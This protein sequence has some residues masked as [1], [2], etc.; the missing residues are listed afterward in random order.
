MRGEKH[1]KKKLVPVVISILVVLGQVSALADPLSD[2]LQ[3]QQNQLQQDKNALKAV[4]D[5][6]EELESKIEEM[7]MHIED[8]LRIIEDNKRQ[9]AQT[10]TEI[11]GAQGEVKKA[12]DEVQESKELLG[13]RVRAMYKSGNSGYLEMI[14]QS[15]NI[16]DFLSKIEW[17]NR[18]VSFDKKMILTLEEKERELVKKKE[19]L[20][21][22]KEEL[23]ALKN[24]NDQ[25]LAHLKTSMDEQKKLIDEVKSQEKIFAAKVKAT[26]NLV[27]TTMRQIQQ[28]RNSV[29]AYNPSRG[30]A[31]ISDNAIIDYASNFLGTPYVW[32][33]TKPN[34]GFDCSGFT[35]YV[36]AHFGIKLGRTTW[37]QINDGVAVARQDLQPGDLVFYGSKGNPTHMGIYVGNDSYIHA[38][39]TGDVIKIS[40]YIRKDY[41]TARRVK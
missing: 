3:N 41:I 9:I 18:I 26:Q 22:K 21:K 34:P 24:S 35:Q 15:R 29:P 32:G 10:E 14:L 4:E 30:A 33:G 8:A 25:K 6:R 31:P 39:R 40:P 37:D 20:E 36:F 2:Q 13:K 12:E 19:A 5:K 1:M 38:P 23:V 27:N 11:K 17:I 16:S 28:I 7:D